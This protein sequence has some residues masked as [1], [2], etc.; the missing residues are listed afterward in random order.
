MK[1]LY[2]NK[3]GR[4]IPIHDF[5]CYGCIYFTEGISIGRCRKVGLM[6]LCVGDSNHYEFIS[7]SSDVLTYE[8]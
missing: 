6:K 3:V 7:S 2:K 8:N 1:V 4:L 5:N